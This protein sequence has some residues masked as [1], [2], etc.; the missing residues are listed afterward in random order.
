MTLL[1]LYCFPLARSKFYEDVQA[2]YWLTQDNV[3]SPA[4]LFIVIP[5]P[6]ADKSEGPIASNEHKPSAAALLLRT[7]LFP[8][9]ETIL[10]PDGKL[11]PTVV[12]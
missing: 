3:L 11:N 7:T 2:V 8:V 5:P 6:S 9:I 12:G 10:V 4:E 1:I